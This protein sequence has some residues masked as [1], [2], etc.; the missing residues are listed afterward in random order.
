[1]WSVGLHPE[2]AKSK[3]GEYEEAWHLLGM[4]TKAAT[5]VLENSK[6][7]QTGGWSG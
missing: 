1:M 6:T 4:E 5:E 7:A 2:L 3:Y